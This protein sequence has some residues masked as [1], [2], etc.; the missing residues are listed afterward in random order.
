MDNFFGDFHAVETY[1]NFEGTQ[2]NLPSTS[3]VAC[4]TEAD[5]GGEEADKENDKLWS[6]NAVKILID[7]VKEHYEEFDK[8]MKKTVWNK[9]A[10]VMTTNLKRNVSWKQCDDKWKSLK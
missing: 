4:D 6:T 5:S 8:T 2:V 3:G 1:I 9:I 7:Q 10:K